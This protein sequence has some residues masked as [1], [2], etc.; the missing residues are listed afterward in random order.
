MVTPA[1][2]PYVLPSAAAIL[3]ALFAIQPLGTSVLGIWGIAQ[4][5]SRRF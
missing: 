2:Q 5:S 3:V 1:F 4:D